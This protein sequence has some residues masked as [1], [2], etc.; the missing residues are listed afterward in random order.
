MDAGKTKSKLFVIS[1][2]EDK[3]EFESV[4]FA[5]VPVIS[6]LSQLFKM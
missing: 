5:F 3:D 6:K 2:L 1:L 4:S